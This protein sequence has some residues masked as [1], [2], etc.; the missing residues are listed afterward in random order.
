MSGIFQ[1]GAD[2]EEANGVHIILTGGANANNIFWQ[3]STKAV[4]GTTA[5]F[6]GKTIL[7]GTSITMNTG[8]AR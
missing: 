1:C 7:A 2:L 8:C 4:I 5:V 3:V 6:N